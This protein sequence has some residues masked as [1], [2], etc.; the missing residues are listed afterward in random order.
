[1]CKLR[2]VL[3]ALFAEKLRHHTTDQS[4]RGLYNFRPITA[5]LG[6]GWGYGDHISFRPSSLYKSR[7]ESP[8]RSAG[9][10]KWSVSPER[11]N[12]QEQGTPLKIDLGEVE[13][14]AGGCE[15]WSMTKNGRKT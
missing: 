5:H 15:A 14:D 12:A 4:Q 13:A 3:R 7:L 8:A 9:R 11:L 2:T 1:M 6:V 10:V